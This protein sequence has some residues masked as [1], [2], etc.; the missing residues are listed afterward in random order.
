MTNEEIDYKV[1]PFEEENVKW[2]ITKDVAKFSQNKFEVEL[3]CMSLK[4]PLIRQTVSEVIPF[5]LDVLRLPRLHKSSSSLEPERPESKATRES[6]WRKDRKDAYWFEICCDPIDTDWSL[7]RTEIRNFVE[8][9]IKAGRDQEND[10]FVLNLRP[11]ASQ[12][13]CLLENYTK[14]SSSVSSWS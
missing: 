2:M 10:K 1:A 9:S 8:G 3:F 4:Y 13:M 6:K 11:F 14:K 7:S 12:I 5:N